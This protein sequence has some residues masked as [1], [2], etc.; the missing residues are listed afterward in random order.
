MQLEGYG[1]GQLEDDEEY[2]SDLEPMPQNLHT[3]NAAA[4]A[5][6]TLNQPKAL[7]GSKT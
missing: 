7:R 4:A 1:M 3:L 2:G 5:T 6:T